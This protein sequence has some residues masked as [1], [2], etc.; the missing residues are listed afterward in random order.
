LR[1]ET[2]YEFHLSTGTKVEAIL[3]SNHYEMLIVDELFSK[4]KSSEVDRGVSGKIENPTGSHFWIE[5]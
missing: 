1:I 4:L 2:L 5:N 3:V